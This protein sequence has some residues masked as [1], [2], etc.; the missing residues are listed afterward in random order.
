MVLNVHVGYELCAS[1]FW[2]VHLRLFCEGDGEGGKRM[3]SEVEKVRE[4][5][6]K[7]RRFCRKCKKHRRHDSRKHCF[8]WWFVSHVESRFIY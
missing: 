6:K 5:L 7:R 3:R 4:H 2:M 1:W 8:I